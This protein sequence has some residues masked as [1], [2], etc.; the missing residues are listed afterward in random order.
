MELDCITINVSLAIAL[1]LLVPNLPSSHLR[2]AVISQS[3]RP[4]P[5]LIA[6]FPT[7]SSNS[8]STAHHVWHNPFLRCVVQLASW[9]TCSSHRSK[10]LLTFLKYIVRNTDTGGDNSN[11]LT[12]NTVVVVLGGKLRLCS[13]PASRLTISMLI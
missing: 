13:Y 11:Q 6:V 1:L 4:T 12:E 3:I 8:A 9:P 5:G 2:G 10:H 7:S